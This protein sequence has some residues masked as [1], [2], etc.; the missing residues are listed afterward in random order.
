[1]HILHRY[2]HFWYN[3]C[4][5]LCLQLVSGLFRHVSVD[6]TSSSQVVLCRISEPS[7]RGV[8]VGFFAQHCP[9]VFW[10]GISAMGDA[11]RLEYFIFVIVFRHHYDSWQRVALFIASSRAFFLCQNT[12][13]KTTT[14]FRSSHCC[15]KMMYVIDLI[16]H[17][18]I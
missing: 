6:V 3:S 12:S 5:M 8:R 4:R 7:P 2:R 16:T 9:T 15:R 14:A 10:V 18:W 13:M 17:H 1:M 11:P